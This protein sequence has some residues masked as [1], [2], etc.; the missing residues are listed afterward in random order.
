MP[1]WVA[2]G[3]KSSREFVSK[4]GIVGE[5][6][7]AAILVRDVETRDD[8]GRLVPQ[9]V[10]RA[11]H[12]WCLKG[13]PNRGGDEAEHLAMNQE[14]E[15]FKTWFPERFWHEKLTVIQ[16]ERASDVY[17]YKYI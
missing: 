1:Q 8:N 7:F 6:E 13:H 14:Y 10:K 9:K 4:L 17:V 15:D 16:K 11:W 2:P 12:R 3:A 5:D